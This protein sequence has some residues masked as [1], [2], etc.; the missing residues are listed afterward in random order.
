MIYFSLVALCGITFNFHLFLFEDNRKLIFKII[1]KNNIIFFLDTFFS[2]FFF[3]FVTFHVLCILIVLLYEW[4]LTAADQVR[5][6]FSVNCFSWLHFQPSTENTHP[7]TQ[8]NVHMCMCGCNC[9]AAVYD[10]AGGRCG[11]WFKLAFT[12]LMACGYFSLIIIII[13]FR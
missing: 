3:C 4:S 12:W 2:H 11:W 8:C 13:F 10:D 1:F 9:C 5:E 7:T 6:T